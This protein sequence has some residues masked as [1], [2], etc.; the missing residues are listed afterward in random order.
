MSFYE[1]MHKSLSAL[2]QDGETLKYPI[3]GALVQSKRTYFGYLGLTDTHLLLVLLQGDTKKICY[4][5]RI[6]LDCIQQAK[7]KKSLIPMQSVLSIDLDDGRHATIRVSKKVY[8]FNSQAENL[9][10][11]LSAIKK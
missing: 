3:Y 6:P 11:F 7:V 4:T 5:N 2:L 1:I 9:K 10:S 8:G